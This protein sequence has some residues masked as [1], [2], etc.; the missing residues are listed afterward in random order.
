MTKGA[1]RK[2]N[3]FIK[4]NRKDNHIE[5]AANKLCVLLTMEKSCNR[6]TEFDR[7]ENIANHKIC[8]KICTQEHSFD[9]HAI[10]LLK[11]I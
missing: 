9:N 8:H 3:A 2:E 5:G 11:G 10:S 1:A 4:N 7:K 6:E